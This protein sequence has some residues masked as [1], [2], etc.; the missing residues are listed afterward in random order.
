VIRH[1]GLEVLGFE[2]KCSALLLHQTIPLAALCPSFDMASK[3]LGDLGIQMNCRLFKTLCYRVAD[4]IMVNRCDNVVDDLWQRPGLRL[5]ICI[6]GGRLRHRQTKRGRKKESA[7]RHGYYTD[8]I[9]PWLMT[10]TCVDENGK[11]CRDIPPIYDGTVKDIDKE[12]CGRRRLTY[13]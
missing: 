5:L 2:H 8:W 7:K 11:K 6:D 10:I 4:R 13:L 9:D 3:V 12:I 1:L